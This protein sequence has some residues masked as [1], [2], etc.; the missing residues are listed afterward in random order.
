MLLKQEGMRG[1]THPRV[2]SSGG[3]WAGG[4]GVSGGGGHDEGVRGISA[5]DYCAGRWGGQLDKGE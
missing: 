3:P 4:S 2:R 5:A 1:I